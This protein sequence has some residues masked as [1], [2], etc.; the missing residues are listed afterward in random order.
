MAAAAAAVEATTSP[1]SST[2]GVFAVSAFRIECSESPLPP[3][4]PPPWP[5][6][7]LAAQLC[8]EARSQLSTAA[9]EQN[10]LGVSGGRVVAAFVWGRRVLQPPGM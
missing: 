1:T 8:E 5:R 9:A 3:T 4:P 7:H 6:G 10:S 2:T